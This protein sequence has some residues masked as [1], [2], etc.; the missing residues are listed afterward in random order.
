[1]LPSF[2]LLGGVYIFWLLLLILDI[3]INVFLIKII[4]FCR[5]SCGNIFF[6]LYRLVYRYKNT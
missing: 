1:M 5:L 3:D 6:T 4:Y 2:L